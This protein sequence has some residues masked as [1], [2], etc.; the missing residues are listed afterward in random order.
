[1]D[2]KVFER[3][4]IQARLLSAIFSRSVKNQ[5]VLKGGMAFRALFGSQRYT[6]DIDLAQA[7]A[8]P[9]AAL[10]RLMR[11]SID[12]C[13]QGFLVDVVV[14]EPKQTD[15][16]ARWKIHGKTAGG[17]EIGLTVEVSRCG[18]PDGHIESRF[19]RP[20][21]DAR[22]ANVKIDVFDQ[23]A[24]AVSKVFALASPNRLAPRDLYDLDLLVQMEV[25]PPAEMFAAVSDRRALVAEV[26]AKIDSMSWAHFECEV[27]PFLPDAMRSRIDAEEFEAMRVRVGEAVENWLATDGGPSCE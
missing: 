7:S 22:C 24:L 23:D 14:T 17:T 9:L 4:L 13:V 6:K 2:A 26:W 15:T 18:I 8:Q 1:M 20:P 16:T 25:R 27:I 10:Q 11:Q 21:E 3:D 19:F 5:V 12:A